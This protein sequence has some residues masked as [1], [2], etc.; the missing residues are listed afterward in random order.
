L[1]CH[2]LADDSQRVAQLKDL[3][4]KL[5]IGT[6]PSTVLLPWLPTPA[7][8]KKMWSTK[9]IYDIVVEAIRWRQAS[10]ITS[11]D[12]LQ[13]LLDGGDDKLVVIGV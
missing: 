9:K 13:F 4:D 7:M 8:L 11:D 10:G 2:E 1:S 6:T 12:T 3:Y 5:D